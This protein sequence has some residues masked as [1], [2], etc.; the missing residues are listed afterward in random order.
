MKKSAVS[1]I[2]SRDVKRLTEPFFKNLQWLVFVKAK[3]FYSNKFAVKLHE[4]RYEGGP[5]R[6]EETN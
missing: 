5:S 6:V 3:E 1:L 4:G 2:L